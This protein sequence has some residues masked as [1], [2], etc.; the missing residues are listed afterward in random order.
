MT[1]THWVLISIIL[2]MLLYDVLAVAKYWPTLSQVLRD[3]GR[4]YSALPF[5]AAFL[6]GHWFLNHNDIWKSGWM[7][8][9]PILIG[10]CVWDYF[11]NQKERAWVW[12]RYPGIYIALG[13]AGGYFLWPQHL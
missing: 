2:G 8:A 6:L 13:I 3:W 1:I 9:L 5:T 7:F 11:W 12:Y 4:S 10:L